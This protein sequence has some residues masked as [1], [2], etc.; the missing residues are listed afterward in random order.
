[1]RKN[2]EPSWL[3][4][5]SGRHQSQLTVTILFSI[6]QI[7]LVLSAKGEALAQLLKLHD[8]LGQ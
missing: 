3:G 6:H 4:I 7:S 2:D 5:L 8:G 1:M